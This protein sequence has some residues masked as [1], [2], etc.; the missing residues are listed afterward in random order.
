MSDQFINVYVELLNS[1]LME[2]FNKNLV[3]QAQNK[4]SEQEILTLKESN[5]KLVNNSQELDSIRNQLSIAQNDL[6]VS[7][8]S[9]QH[10]ETFKSELLKAREEIKDR[11]LKL[12]IFK[13]E[14]SSLQ[15]IIE[16]LNIDIEN[17]KLENSLLLK[18]NKKFKKDSMKL[19]EV[20]IEE[21]LDKKKKKKEPITVEIEPLEIVEINNILSDNKDAG[22][23]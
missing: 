18:E 5:S 23:F 15:K 16:N 8:N 12:D 14:I 3:L 11:N 19:E 17:I 13:D 21:P 20:K 6:N 7:R 9:N 10:L 2:A 1:T 22:T 4:I